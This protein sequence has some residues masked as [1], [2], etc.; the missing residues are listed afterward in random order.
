MS[1]RRGSAS[2]RREHPREIVAKKFAQ[3]GLG[4]DLELRLVKSYPKR[5]FVLQYG[6]SDLDFCARLVEHLG[7]SYFVDCSGGRDV[8]VFT[9]ANAGFRAHAQPASV[10]FLGERV[11]ADHGV[12]GV[13][14]IEGTVR[15]VPA[16][17]SVK[18][19]NYR[20][21]RVPLVATAP[22]AERAAGAVSEYG[23]HFKTREE[24]EAIAR[25]R[26]EEVLATQRVFD[27]RSN[28]HTL[29]AQL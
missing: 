11:D 4:R 14:A 29:T 8:I 28:V 1:R 20:T 7:I 26:A 3:A 2:D 27:G 9:D 17:Y 25:V 15:A 16:T 12:P 19:Y 13:A 10:P 22:I 18:D 6:E 21:P 5:E 24:A 23:D